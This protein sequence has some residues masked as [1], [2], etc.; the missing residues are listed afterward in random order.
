MAAKTYIID[1]IYL[2]DNPRGSSGVCLV[3]EVSCHAGYAPE[4]NIQNQQSQG[5]PTELQGRVG[6][7]ARGKDL[8]A[9]PLHFYMLGYTGQEWCN[10]TN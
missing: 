2:K 6:L 8:L 1:I 10:M 4:H 9:W 7:W 3:P 5:T